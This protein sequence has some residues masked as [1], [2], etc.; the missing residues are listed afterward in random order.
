[1]T[2]WP[3]ASLLWDV[4]R[5]K[6]PPPDLAVLPQAMGLAFC[7]GWLPGGFAAAF[8]LRVRDR[9]EADWPDGLT[10]FAGAF[11]GAAGA[12]WGLIAALVLLFLA[13]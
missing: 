8:A 13:L 3:A 2:T 10:R 7:V 11:L 12:V 1:M 5:G 4:I 9:R 6:I